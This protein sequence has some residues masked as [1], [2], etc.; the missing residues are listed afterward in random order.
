MRFLPSGLRA[1]IFLLESRTVNGGQWEE[2]DF[3]ASL[4]H[5]PQPPIQRQLL[6]LGIPGQPSRAVSWPKE[7][8]LLHV[9]GCGSH[10][11]QVLLNG[12]GR[13]LAQRRLLRPCSESL[14]SFLALGLLLAA[15]ESGKEGQEGLRKLGFQGPGEPLLLSRD[16]YLLPEAVCPKGL[17]SHH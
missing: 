12:L 5:P 3:K 10:Q 14:S 13:P 9:V 8:P 6:P 1:V 17:M 15:R 16:S 4:P 11:E 7:R 2:P